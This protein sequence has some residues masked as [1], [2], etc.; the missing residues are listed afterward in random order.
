MSLPAPVVIFLL[1]YINSSATLP[2]NIEAINASNSNL[3]C[4]N[5]SL[6]GSHM[7]TPSACPRGIIVTLCKGSC[8][9]TFSITNACPA[10]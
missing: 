8:P 6:S 2:P 4:E 5:L 9:S 3:V 10:S 1:P 7:V